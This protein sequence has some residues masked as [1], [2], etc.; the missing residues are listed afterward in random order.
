MRPRSRLNC[1]SHACSVPDIEFCGNFKVC[2]AQKYCNGIGIVP[3]SELY[4]LKL[5]QNS[6]RDVERA[7][8]PFTSWDSADIVGFDLTTDPAEWEYSLHMEG[9]EDSAGLA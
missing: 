8:L 9:F 6:N 2:N 4:T 3:I 1:K 5:P 7:N